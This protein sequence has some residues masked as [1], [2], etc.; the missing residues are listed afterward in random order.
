M[1]I[2][3]TREMYLAVKEELKELAVIIRKLKFSR[4]LPNRGDRLLWEIESEIDAKSR[5]ARHLHIAYCLL[6]GTEYNDIE[7][8]RAENSPS[9]SLINGYIEEYGVLVEEALCLSA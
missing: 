1:K 8:P 2:F 7:K 9:W 5:K 4:K 3:K 6:R